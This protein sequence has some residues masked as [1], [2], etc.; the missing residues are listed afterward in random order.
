MGPIR[1]IGP[2]EPI[3]PQRTLINCDVAARSQER[4]ALPR[5]DLSASQDPAHQGEHNADE[6]AGSERKI[7]SEIALLDRN[8]SWQVSEP[9]KPGWKFPKQQPDR[10]Q[11]DPGDYREF[12]NFLHNRNYREERGLGND[13]GQAE[14]VICHL[15]FVIDPASFDA[16]CGLPTTFITSILS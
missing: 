12:S 15:S 4:E 6:N 9:A 13:L 10:H 2:I 16:R 8:I 1:P 7:E 14:F 11:N 3:G 5:P